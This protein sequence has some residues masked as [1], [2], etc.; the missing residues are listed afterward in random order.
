MWLA[1]AAVVGITVMGEASVQRAVPI[2][3]ATGVFSAGRAVT[4]LERFA[5]EPRPLGSPASERAR[6]YVA[7]E[8]RAA[9]LTVEIPSAVGVRDAA[10]LATFGR[11]QNVVAVLPGTDSTGT[12][13]LAAHYDSAAVSPGASDDG[14]AVAAILETVRALRAGPAL[15]NDLVVLVTDG[16]EDGLL[17][18][19]AFVREHPLGSQ[20]GIALNFEARGVTGPSV[21]FETSRDNAG[22]VSLFADAAPHPR[23]DSSMVEIY[24]LLPNN[25]DFTALSGAG[26]SGLNFAYFEGAAFYHTAGDSLANL[27]RGSLQH[28]GEN[29][30]AVA[31][32]LGES[33]L[34]SLAAK[35]D[36][37]YFRVLGVMVGYSDGAVWP[38]AVLSILAV[39]AFAVLAHRRRHATVGGLLAAT[40]SALLPLLVA[41]VLGQALWSLLAWLQ[42]QYD[43]MGGLLHQPLPFQAAMAGLGILA[44]LGWLLLMRHRV[45][46][47]AIAVAGAFWVGLLGV[48]CAA[49][50]PGAAYLFTIPALVCALAGIVAVGVD[51]LWLNVATIG[52]AAAIS[53]V[54][55][56]AVIRN[57]FNGVGLV[58]GGAGSLLVVLLGLT[59]TQVVDLVWVGRWAKEDKARRPGRRTTIAAAAMTLLLVLAG[60]W[61]NTPDTDQP[62]RTHLAYILDSGTGQA[63]WVSAETEPTDWTRRHVSGTD[64]SGLPPGYQRGTLWTGAASTIDAPGPQVTLRS[65]TIDSVTVHVAS[66]RGAPSVTLRTEVPIVGATATMPGEAP[67]SAVVEGTRANTWPGE[68]RFRGLPAEGVEITV[69][70]GTPDA[71][72]LTAIDETHGLEDAPGFVH[73]PANL[74]AGTREDGDIVA[75]ATTFP[76]PAA[77]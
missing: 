53:A 29:M 10:G 59:L 50:A 64:T 25:S 47:A 30:L 41:A 20:G 15:R 66:P 58:F 75:V 8:L 44:V 40:G 71:F 7:E 43:A 21:M 77:P 13:L 42:P 19:E 27:D 57:V 14:A 33:D 9:G 34:R 5:T 73:R 48:V 72:R 65:R 62:G 18:A 35:H 6:N 55:L 16:E 45:G 61:L 36:R 69:R 52:T 63:F 37:T 60:L 2:D 23:G 22:L 32:A 4:H 24:R 38:L 17:G 1:V 70:I 31:R 12:L 49:Y 54:L 68:I 67:V 39:M 3:G 56:P 51:R 26:F 74:V 11:V 28:H 46:G 76:V